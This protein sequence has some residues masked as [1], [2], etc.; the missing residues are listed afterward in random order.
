MGVLS[1]KKNIEHLMNFLIY[2]KEHLLCFA[3]VLL[4]F[5]LAGVVLVHLPIYN[6]TN[7]EEQ[8]IMIILISIILV[9]SIYI[10]IGLNYMLTI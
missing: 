5:I 1:M 7:I 9:Q 2:V 6:P 10:I 4:F 3:L 8:Q